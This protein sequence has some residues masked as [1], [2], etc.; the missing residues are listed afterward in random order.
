[1]TSGRLKIPLCLWRRQEVSQCC[2]LLNTF[3]LLQTA[4]DT[5]P[6]SDTRPWSD[7]GLC[8]DT[9]PCYD[10]G[11]CS[12]TRPSSDPGPCSYTRPCPDPGPFSDTGPVMGLIK[13]CNNFPQDNTIRKTF[14]REPSQHQHIFIYNQIRMI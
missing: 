9:R 3:F 14:S 13:C 10:P 12:D 1:M 7:P 8:S 11:P 4:A 5:G 2:F 6:C